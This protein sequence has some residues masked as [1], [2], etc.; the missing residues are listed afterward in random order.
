MVEVVTQVN[1]LRTKYDWGAERRPALALQYWT[2]AF[3]CMT[4]FF[5]IGKQRHINFL[6]HHPLW[7]HAH[8]CRQNERYRLRPDKRHF[9]LRS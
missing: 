9:A 6:S 5:Y 3:A 1:D 2:H 8:I 7:A 4:E